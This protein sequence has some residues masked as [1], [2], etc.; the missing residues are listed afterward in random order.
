MFSDQAKLGLLAASFLACLSTL[1]TS[2]SFHTGSRGVGTLHPPTKRLCKDAYHKAKKCG[3]IGDDS[4]SGSEDEHGGATS[5]PSCKAVI[6]NARKCE[7]T[8]EKAYRHINMGGCAKMILKSTVCK[9]EW[10]EDRHTEKARDDC[11]KE[12]DPIQQELQVCQSD[13]VKQ[14]FQRAGLNADGTMK[15]K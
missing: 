14:F 8:V 10:C 1:F 15:Q 3:W 6:S 2:G 5:N 12:C 13:H 11:K 9:L 4:R 7:R